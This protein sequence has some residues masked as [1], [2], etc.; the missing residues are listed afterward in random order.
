ML[1]D[2]KRFVWKHLRIESMEGWFL[3]SLPGRCPDPKFVVI[4][5]SELGPFARGL[6][7]EFLRN[8]DSTSFEGCAGFFY[9]V[10]MQDKACHARFGASTLST[11]AEHNMGLCAGKGNFKPALSF[12]HG[13]VVYLFK[14]EFVNIKI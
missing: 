4:K 14:A 5:V 2:K 9:I 6:R 10:G 8:S 11:K 7:A 13:L 12:T 3:E 1:P